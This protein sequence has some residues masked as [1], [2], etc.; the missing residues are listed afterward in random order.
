[1]L[2]P[3][4]LTVG[5]MTQKSTKHAAVRA[6][7]ERVGVSGLRLVAAYTRLSEGD[8]REIITEDKEISDE[9]AEAVT[10]IME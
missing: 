5:L 4:P 2:L 8:L 3:T 10:R 6:Y 9:I 7:L 1:M